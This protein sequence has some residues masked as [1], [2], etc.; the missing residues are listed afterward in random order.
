[1][2]FGVDTNPKERSTDSDDSGSQERFQSTSEMADNAVNRLQ[3]QLNDLQTVMRQQNDMIGNLQAAARA[4]ALANSNTHLQNSN[5]LADEV[6]KQFVKSTVKFYKDV[7]PRNPKLAFDGSNYTK[8]ENAIDRTL[9]HATLDEALLSIVESDEITSSKDLFELLRSKC[10]RSGRR[11]KII[12][13]EKILKFATEKSPA[14]EAWLACFCAIMSDVERAK[15]TVNELGGLILQ[16][17]AKSPPGTDLKNFEYSISQPLDDM[18]T[19]P[20]FGQVTT[21]IQSALSKITNGLV[22]SP[23]SIPSDV[24]MSINA[25]QSRQQ[26]YEPPHKRQNP[27]S[28]AQANAKF[29]VEKAAYFRGKGH[30]KSLNER[31]GYNCRYCGEVGHW[32]SDCDAY[33]EDVR[34]G[35]VDAPPPNHAE[36][37]SRF[38]P[39]SRN[40]QHKPTAT[41]SQPTPQSN[42]RIRKIDV[43]DACDGTVLLDSGSTINVSGNSRF[44]KIKSRLNNPLTISLA[45]SQYM[46]PVE[47]I[48][49][50]MIPTPTGVM[51]IDDVFYCKGIKG[52]ILS[53][54][55]LVEDGWLFVHAHTDAK[56]ISP[57]GITFSLNYINHCWNVATLDPPAMLS[58]I[59]QRPSSKLFL[60]HCRL[61]HAA[62]PVVQRFI[63]R[64]LPGIKLDNKPFFCVQCAKSKATATKGN[65]AT[66]NIPRD[67]PLDLCMTDVAGPFNMDI[68]G[69][70]YLITFRDHASTYTYCAIMTSCHEV[71]DKI[72]AWVLHLKT[73]LGRAPAYLRCDNAAEYVGNLCD[74][75][76][77]VGT[78]LAPISP[79]HPQQN[80]EAKRANWTFGDMARTMLHDSK[81]PKIYWSYAYLTA[82]YIHNRI[83]NSRVE[84][85]P[86]EKLYGI[87]PSPNELYPFGSRAIVHVP[88]DIRTDKIEERG[89]ECLMLGYPKAGSGW[90]FYV[91]SQK[92]IVHTSDAVFPEYP[93]LTVKEARP[94]ETIE[95]EI[96]EPL[97]E[98]ELADTVL[99]SELKKVIRR[100]KLVLGGEPT[101]EIAAAKLKAIE[102]L[103]VAQ[104]HRLPKTIKVALSG[105]D[106]QNWK[107]AA[108]YEIEKFASLGVWEPVNPHKGSKALGA[109]WVFTI[110]RKT[111]GSIDKFRARYVAKGFN[112]VMGTDCNETYAPTA[113]LN[114]LR[115]LLSIAQSKHFPTATFDI[116][117]AYLYSPIEEEVY[118]QPPVEIMPQWK[119]KIMRLKKAMYGTRQ[120]ARCWWKFFSSKMRDIGFT[121]SELEPS[122]YFCR[123][124]LEFVV[125]WLHVDDGF[126]MGSSQNVLDDLHQA[127]SMQMEVKWS[128][129][130]DKIVGINISHQDNNILLD[131]HLLVDQ[132]LRDYPRACFPK[133]STLPEDHIEINPGDPVNSTEYRS[134]LG[135]LMY[136]CS[137]TRPDLSYSVN[138]LA[139]YSANPSEEHWSALDVLIGYLKRNRDLKMVFRKGKEVMQLWSDANWGGEHKRSTSGYM[140]RHNGNSIAWGAKRQTVVAL[141]TCA[142]EYIALSEGSQIIAQLQNLLIDI[143]QTTPIEI[144]CNN[145]AAIL[146]AGDNASKKKTRYLSRAFY[147]INDFIRQYDIK[148][149][150]TDMH[151]Q[152][153][154]IFTKRLGPNII[155]KALEK[156]NLVGSRS[157]PREGVLETRL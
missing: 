23:G 63:R 132:I 64:Y 128:E 97:P 129:S 95:A 1:M 10:K 25:I 130:V 48:G 114:T 8:W 153:A 54:G 28:P 3:S 41:G 24:E 147:F 49:S 109:R 108:E 31:Y 137:G 118:V 138:L 98:S 37:G 38:V 148:I 46:A 135:S 36:K 143:E 76:A 102:S 96:T 22:L 83:P 150:W 94:G 80:G 89:V 62:E 107:A 39:P 9:Q 106:S 35:R 117:S 43:P 105:T 59:S 55:R 116:S 140:V 56:L 90:L 75:L 133:R 67:N 47:F 111:D 12:L 142:A 126:A 124:G 131:Q 13:T 144:Y 91:P 84:T 26:R 40:T 69:C 11:H 7:N 152:V 30:T 18:A 79:Y 101:K 74:R 157:Q 70:R 139:R 120:A 123:R 127:I 6:M 82:A 57:M 156:I 19:I 58:K 81:L 113:S 34:F 125:I 104:E 66:S 50:L 68:N 77:E 85:S 73:A 32:Y 134:T 44:F 88:K 45:I 52:S 136:L 2:R 141:S 14:S 78:V 103:P 4:Q 5:P 65:G 27:E 151:N 17:L 145:E 119:G 155:E 110:K 61:G 42:G 99:E 20:T 60:W 72:M 122:L 33:W 21:V 93:A 92:R 100:I 86:F 149:Q 53:T 154:D 146:I 87:K 115:L 29:S 51:E 121:A 16:S 112:Q 15:I 71:P